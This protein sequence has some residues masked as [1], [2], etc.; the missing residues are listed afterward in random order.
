M[1]LY[2]TSN[3]GIKE[4][5][6]IREY[7]N[8]RNFIKTIYDQIF[9][10]RIN[11]GI[12]WFSDD[13]GARKIGYEIQKYIE[14]YK[15][16]QITCSNPTKNPNSD[17]TIAMWIWEINK[18]NLKRWG[19]I[20]GKTGSHSWGAVFLWKLKKAITN[21]LPTIK[22]PIPENIKPQEQNQS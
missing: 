3:C 22:L 19:A 18:D 16:G 20:K 2:N 13:I 17:H 15:L 4:F 14:D 1:S 12:I 9:I 5:K 6:G 11:P 21:K 8:P 7:N 10:D